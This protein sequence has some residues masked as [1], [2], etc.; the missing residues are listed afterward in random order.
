MSYEPQALPDDGDHFDL[1]AAMEKWEYEKDRA[2]DAQWERCCAQA[3]EEVSG[4]IDA[5]LLRCAT[6]SSLADA[7]LLAGYLN[8]GHLFDKHL[9]RCP[10]H[11]MEDAE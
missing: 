7:V 5:A 9:E 1:E 4:M 11:E 10:S 2:I 6:N 3:Q 8:R